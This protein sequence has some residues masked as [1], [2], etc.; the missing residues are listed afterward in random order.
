MSKT[1]N[2]SMMITAL[3]RAGLNDNQARILGA[4]IGRE[5]SY[6]DKYLWG[7]H[8]DPKNG[9]VNI[10]IISWQGSRGRG[11]KQ[12]LEAEGLIKDGK[13][14]KGQ[15]SLDV[16]ARFLVNEIRTDKAYARTKKEF[17]DNPDVT[18][19]KG[20]EVLG[21]NFIR[22]RYDDAKYASGHRNRDY[23]Y[24]ALGDVLSTDNPAPPTD[25]SATQ[26]TPTQVTPPQAPVTPPPTGDS[27]FGSNVKADGTGSIVLA[28]GIGVV[29]AQTSFEQGIFSDI[30]NSGVSPTRE[31]ALV[32]ASQAIASA[33]DKVNGQNLLDQDSPLT[34]YVSTL[35]DAL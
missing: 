19:E 25:V 6:Q 15:E 26:S 14:V 21:R 2:M 12:A 31:K 4:E 32:T 23:Y 11:V 33:Y 24:K 3:K 13:I 22:W 34:N 16:M 5:N 1:E 17:L 30:F 29:Q 35:F 7:Y 9:A 18:Y 20:A 10:G 8:S 27:I 28:N